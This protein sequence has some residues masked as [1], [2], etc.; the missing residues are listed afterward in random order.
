MTIARRQ[1]AETDGDGMLAPA[2]SG[3]PEAR[4]SCKQTAAPSTQQATQVV[5][6][7]GSEMC[8]MEG[9]AGLQYVRSERDKGDG[10]AD[11]LR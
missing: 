2:P 3:L 8:L 7:K 1:S 10:H 9:L 4:S 6:F 5:G 11:E